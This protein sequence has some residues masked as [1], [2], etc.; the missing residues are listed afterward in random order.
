[1]NNSIAPTEAFEEFVNVAESVGAARF[2]QILSSTP[3][4]TLTTFLGYF[5]PMLGQARLGELSRE[6]LEAVA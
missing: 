2:R 5:L 6:T 3:D 4:W 1:M